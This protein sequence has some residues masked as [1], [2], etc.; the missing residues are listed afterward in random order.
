MYKE[1]IFNYECIR[2][3]YISYIPIDKY[4]YNIY[5]LYKYLLLLH[6]NNK[7]YEYCKN[8]GF[9]KINCMKNYKNILYCSL[10]AL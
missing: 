5:S 4:L 7:S 10:G 1:L 3:N 6:Y 2:F 9:K 8:L